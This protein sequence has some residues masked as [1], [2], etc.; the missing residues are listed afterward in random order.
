MAA[1]FGKT[2][3]LTSRRYVVVEGIKLP[4]LLEKQKLLCYTIPLLLLNNSLK[5][6]IF[7]DFFTFLMTN[8]ETRETKTGTWTRYEEFKIL[9]KITLVIFFQFCFRIIVSKTLIFE[10]F[11]PQKLWIVAT[12]SE[13]RAF[14]SR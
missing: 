11:L 4:K 6:L 1:T 13:T 10:S 5:M 9:Q 8:G 7:E 14:T 3:V 12:F 2:P